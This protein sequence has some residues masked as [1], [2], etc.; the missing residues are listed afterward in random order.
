MY[1]PTLMTFLRL[2]ADRPS[3][4]GKQDSCNIVATNKSVFC[5][6]IDVQVLLL[7]L[8]GLKNTTPF[9]YS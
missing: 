7:N 1:N 9:R 6:R 2:H 5:I 3:E 4:D 8:K